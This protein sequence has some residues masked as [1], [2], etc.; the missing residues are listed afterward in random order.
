MSGGLLVH[1]LQ[2]ENIPH[3]GDRESFLTKN[4]HLHQV[5]VVAEESGCIC[6]LLCICNWVKFK[7]LLREIKA[8]ATLCR[9]ICQI[10]TDVL[11]KLLLSY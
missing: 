3:H 11:M 7:Y 6:V 4:I 1:H 9:C 10:D 2:P 5:G 8:F